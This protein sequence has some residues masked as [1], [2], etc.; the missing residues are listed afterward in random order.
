MSKPNETLYEVFCE[1][2]YYTN[3]PDKRGIR[4]YEI[5]FIAN[6]DIKKSGFLSAFRRAISPEMGN[7]SAILRA[8]RAKYPDYERFQT[9]QVTQVVNLTDRNKPVRELALMNRDQ[10]MSYINKKGFPIETELYPTVSE[11]R[12]ALL[13]YRESPKAF[14][15]QQEKRRLTLGPTLK[16]VSDMDRL[17]AKRAEMARPDVAV[18][19]SPTNPAQ[20]TPVDDDGPV[21]YDTL[22][23]DEGIPA[24][25]EQ[26][27]LNALLDGV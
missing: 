25:D 27:E 17:N 3:D 9:H 2:K 23:D 26:D 24:F 8:L 16:V 12:Q 10:I 15:E 22:P 19:T 14:E 5:S 7:D 4:P 18:P 21:Q 1:G 11:I 13:D 20:S 6:D